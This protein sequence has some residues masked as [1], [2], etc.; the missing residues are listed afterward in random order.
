MGNSL[1]I[2]KYNNKLKINDLLSIFYY[3]Y[4]KS[5]NDEL[6]YNVEL[7]KNK[8]KI[9]AII[10]QN[11]NKKFI[12]KEFKIGFYIINSYSLRPFKSDINYIINKYINIFNDDNDNNIFDKQFI[13]GAL[14]NNDFINEEIKNI[15]KINE[16]LDKISY[17][18]NYG[19]NISKLNTFKEEY[20]VN[21]LIIFFNDFIDINN[22]NEKMFTNFN[23]GII[24]FDFGKEIN[25]NLNKFCKK[26][27]LFSYNLIYNINELEYINFENLLFYI[28]K[29][30][31]LNIKI[32]DK[33]YKKNIATIFSPNIKNVNDKYYIK[34][35]KYIFLI[36][37]VDNNE[38]INIEITGNYQNEKEK[39]EIEKVEY[40]KNLN[41]IQENNNNFICLYYFYLLMKNLK[42]YTIDENNKKTYKDFIDNNF[43]LIKKFIEENFE[44][45]VLNNQKKFLIELLEIYYVSLNIENEKNNNNI[46]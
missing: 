39:I 12:K 24:F 45:N 22:E 5:D 41:E 36:D 15:K 29:D 10:N 34:G 33:E 8:K 37:N 16:E 17:E 13:L 21:K 1:I 43:A 42:K 31:N 19:N 40:Q 32:N 2:P 35:N 23:D 25:T 18:Y 44:E 27:F 26:N 3:K 4:D 38:K 28:G 11:I 7:Y 20:K 9:F 46:N 6:F 14:C 30:L